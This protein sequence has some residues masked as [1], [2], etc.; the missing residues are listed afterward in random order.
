M[1]PRYTRRH[2]LDQ[3]MS[4]D[5]SPADRAAARMVLIIQLAVLVAVI[6]LV[7]VFG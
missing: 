6:T 3:A 7:A 5:A 4:A 2:Y 1:D